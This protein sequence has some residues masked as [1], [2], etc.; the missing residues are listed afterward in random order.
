[1]IDDLPRD[2]QDQKARQSGSESFL[3]LQGNRGKF[4]GKGLAKACEV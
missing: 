3:S 2:N 4:P 1:M